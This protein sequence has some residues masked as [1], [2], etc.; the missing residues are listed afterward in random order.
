M[1]DSNNHQDLIDQLRGTPEQMR[2]AIAERTREELQQPGE[3]GGL[4]VVEILCDLQDW[5]EISGERIARI[6]HE[7]AP[8]LEAYDDSLWSIEHDYASRDGF[9]VLD[10][11]ALTRAKLV[12][13]LETISASDWQR[14]GEL[15]GRGRITVEWLVEQAARH[16]T[17][18]IE[19]I[20]EALA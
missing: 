3:D 8:Y 18:H 2:R 14:Q 5:E 20:L 10:S 19:A 11:F 17:L 12:D 6:L 16:D 9:A 15:E 4:S 13:M 7:H 1:I